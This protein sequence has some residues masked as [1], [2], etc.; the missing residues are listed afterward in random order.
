M[1]EEEHYPR[2]LNGHG[3]LFGR[4]LGKR[5][6]EWREEQARRMKNVEK[7]LDRLTWAA[8]GVMISLVTAS[9]TMLLTYF[10][11]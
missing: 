5:F 1:S 9:L 4:S 11:P 2:V 3:C 7:K 6:E 10:A 8:V